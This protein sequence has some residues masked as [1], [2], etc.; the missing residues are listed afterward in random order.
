MFFPSI[1]QTFSRAGSH[2]LLK[3]AALTLIGLALLPRPATASLPPEHQAV[4]AHA[5][6]TPSPAP[7]IT[8]RWAPDLVQPPLSHAIR[9]KAAGAADW[10]PAV[11]LPG[12]ALSHT[13]ADVVPGLAY[14]YEISKV[15]S[16]YTGYG[17]V[18]AAIALPAVEHRGVIVLLVD[19]TQSAPLAP[20]LARLQA[21]LAGD[22]WRVVRHDLPPTLPPPA[23]KSLVLEAC[24]AHPGEVRS[25]LLLGRVAVPYSGRYAPDAHSD[26][27]GAWPAD[28]YYGD[29]DGEWTDRHVNFTHTLNADP[30]MRER[31]TNVPGDGKFDAQGLPSPVELAVGRVDLS[32]LPAFAASETEL[33]RR[34]LDKN[35][36]FRHGLERVERRALAA[37][38]I[39]FL[40]G[41]ESF[42]VGAYAAFASLV[43]PERISNLNTLYPGRTGMWLPTLAAED[44]LLAFGAGWGT[45]TGAQGVA[46]TAGFAAQAPRGVFV[47]LM[48]S[49][50]GDW[51]TRDNLLRASLASPGLGL[52]AAWS[53]RPHWFLHPMATGAT[54]G[55][56]TRLTQ[57]NRTTYRAPVNGLTGSPHIALLGDPTLRLHPVRPPA[58]LR[59]EPAPGGGLALAWDASPDAD[60][61]Y[62]VY[63]A[64]GPDAEFV[65]LHPA[66]L[67]TRTF[68]DPAPA[69]ADGAVY[70]VRALRLE[71]GTGGTYQNLSQGVFW[72]ASPAGADL[73]PP[74]VVLD[75]P[76]AIVTNLVTISAQ[77]WDDVA[78]AQVRLLVDGREVGPAVSTPPYTFEWDSAKVAD[79]T[80][81]LAALATDTAGRSRLSP[82]VAVEVVNAPA[83]PEPQPEPTPEPE[84][85]PGKKGKSGKNSTP[86]PPPSGDTLWLD[87]ALPAGAIASTTA[88]GDWSWIGAQPAPFSGLR[89]HETGSATGWAENILELGD[90]PLPV[91]TG[92]TLFVHV[93]LDPAS[94]PR[95][96]TLTWTSAQGDFHS[97]TWGPKSSAR[98]KAPANQARLGAVPAAGAWTLLE[99]PAS[100]VG[101]EGRQIRRLSFG[102]LEGRAVWDY[103]GR[104][105]A[106]PRR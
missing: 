96:L 47:F 41:G 73:A 78:V 76:P 20:E 36:R 95:E 93:W 70:M 51:D 19:N 42:S 3:G 38:H 23:V 14:E 17:Y 61:G 101:L 45:W 27:I 82:S 90:A 22:G 67:A 55:D 5:S 79:G 6:V 105:A 106:A 10:G 98:G 85:A 37:D 12:H 39:G 91:A 30:E 88:G 31:L 92:D 49:Y 87:D 56:A 75:P 48:G 44:H 53:G 102:S 97:A 32:R 18:Q 50:F 34:Y 52:A 1:L 99:V 40:A 71:E 28:A 4:Q 9:R 63:R 54:I 35:H 89:A 64:D 69:P 29:I 83:Q 58:A 59:A 8:L 43:G 62:H 25:V 13:D 7:S 80:R 46:T 26:H 65:R 86:P 16:A 66:P 15:H 104:A 74:T 100:A 33:L 11:V 72:S 24:R 21:D 81:F 68:L 57:N 94:P 2:S 84:P 77:A 60:L 103:A